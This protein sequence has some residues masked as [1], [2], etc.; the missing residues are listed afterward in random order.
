MLDLQVSLFSFVPRMKINWYSLNMFSLVCVCSV[1][2]PCAVADASSGEDAVCSGAAVR[3]AYR[4]LQRSFRGWRPLTADR[5]KTAAGAKAQVKQL[6]CKSRGRGRRSD[7]ERERARTGE[8]PT[9]RFRERLD[10]E[11][12]WFCSFVFLRHGGSP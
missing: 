12:L 1:W 4:P 5:A 9:Y 2:A 6:A 7:R 8:I 10:F 11:D 3:S